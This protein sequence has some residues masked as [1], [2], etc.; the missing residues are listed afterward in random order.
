M[1]KFIEKNKRLLMFYRTVLRTLGWV[2]LCM[3]GIGFTMVILESSRGS[4][5]TFEGF[6]GTFK[7][8]YSVF[9]NIGLVA[10]GFSQFVRFCCE[11]DSK[12][13]LLLRYGEKIFYLYAVIAVWQVCVE[14]WLVTTGKTGGSVYHWLLFML[15]GTLLYKSARVLIF[16]GLGQLLKQL[17]LAI[18]AS[19]V[20]VLEN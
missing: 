5:I 16:V 15:P 4:G 18:E 14:F 10:L 2:L 12:K 6:L 20:E 11:K 3:G 7:R 19:R 8:S 13:G 9:V 17:I 1:V